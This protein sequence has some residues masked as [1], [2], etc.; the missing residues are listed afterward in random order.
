VPRPC[1]IPRARI[2]PMQRPIAALALAV[3]ALLAGLRLAAAV[4]DTEAMRCAIACGHAPVKGA[5]CCPMSADQGPSFKTCGAGGL[6]LLPL[7]APP[8]AV[9]SAA[10]PLSPPAPDRL[11]RPASGS[12][13]RFAPPRPLDH[14]PL[15]F[16]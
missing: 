5:A 14:V 3:I 2:G 7:A 4:Q 13:P 9:L 11:I 12:G 1:R 15:L 8:P 10:A 6:A 16:G